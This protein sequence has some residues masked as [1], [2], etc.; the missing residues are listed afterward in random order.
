MAAILAVMLP[1]TG[2]GTSASTTQ[3][4]TAQPTTPPA[5]GS[6]VWMISTSAVALLRD[7]GM[8]DGELRAHFDGT[9]TYLI[10]NGNTSGTSG[11]NVIRVRKYTSEVTMESDIVAG[12]NTA[13]AVLYDV[14]AWSLTPLNEQQNP[15]TYEAK[16]AAFAHAHG[17]KFI[18]TP[19]VDLVTAIAPRDGGSR[20]DAF[21]RLG[22]A[23]DAA[24]SADVIDIQAQG[25]EANTPGYV[26]FVRGAAAQARAA[27]P[28]VHVLAGISTNPNG[29][30]VTTDQLRSVVIAT[31]NVV[32]GYWL[33]IPGGG[34][35]C[36]NCGAPQPQ[37]AV[38]LLRTL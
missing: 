17:F 22:I 27:N 8:S 28:Q 15:S 5:S 23:S 10:L 36:P 24:R 21:L 32:D 13:D 19:A 9:G 16:G 31:R 1:A 30:H 2:C 35:A 25:A 11:W 26:A 29:Q 20:Y 6:P 37:V 4:I 38:E 7:A 33:N 14:E 12:L 34:V 3:A 18:A